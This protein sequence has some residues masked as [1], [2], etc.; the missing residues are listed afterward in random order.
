MS[1]LAVSHLITD[2]QSVPYNNPPYSDL[3]PIITKLFEAKARKGLSFEKLAQAIG[4]DEIWVAAAF[5]GQA[6]LGP[7]DIEALA[8]V[9]DVPLASIQNELGLIGGPTVVWDLFLRLILSSTA[10]LR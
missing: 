10:C 6:K 9:L 2:G 4:K 3:P 5:Y 7:E 1:Q 8:R